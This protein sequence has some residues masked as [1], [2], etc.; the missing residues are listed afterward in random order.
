MTKPDDVYDWKQLSASTKVSDQDMTQWVPD[1]NSLTKEEQKASMPWLNHIILGHPLPENY[2]GP[3]PITK[4]F[5]EPYFAKLKEDP[6]YCGLEPFTTGP[7]DLYWKRFCAPHDK[8]FQALKD[9]HPEAGNLKTAALGMLAI[10]QVV[11]LSAL[12]IVTA[13]LYAVIG[14][15]GGMGRWKQIEIQTGQNK[16][17]MEDDDFN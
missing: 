8:A 9:K 11:G 7:W 3:R 10:G 2:D 12:A 4:K 1:W 13:P 16:I 15:L 6:D 5:F 14:V 17:T